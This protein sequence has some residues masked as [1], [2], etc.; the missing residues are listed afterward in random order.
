[1]VVAMGVQCRACGR[2]IGT[3]WASVLAPPAAEAAG[4]NAKQEEP[5]PGDNASDDDTN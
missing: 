1:M 4:N 2:A 3:L 5:Y